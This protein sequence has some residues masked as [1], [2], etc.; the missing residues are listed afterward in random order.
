MRYLI[1]NRN[2]KLSEDV[3][4]YL[5]I[6]IKKFGWEYD[7]YNPELVITLG[8]DGTMLEAIHQFSYLSP[9]FLG[10]KTGTLGFL[11]DYTY[12][13]V[14]E[15]LNDLNND[16]YV[17]EIPFLE[18]D[19]NGRKILAVNEFRIENIYNSLHIEVKID[20]CFLEK[21]AGNGLCICG[22]IGSSA[23]NRSLGGAI[24]NS[25]LNLL[26]LSEIVSIHN[27]KYRSLG[28]SMIISGDSCIEL[29][30]NAKNFIICYDHLFLE[31]YEEQVIKFT[32]SKNKFKFI[33]FKKVNYCDRLKTLY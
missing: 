20:D 23:Y 18:A 10:L 1:Y 32:T 22:Q 21:F 27:S 8:G 3:K 12:R 28:S 13:Q 33:H 25:G 14:D 19:I 31:M 15:F 6:N 9:L 16:Y 4:K 24:I 5:I 11:T 26:E 17:S 29:S 7:D 30:V 2:D